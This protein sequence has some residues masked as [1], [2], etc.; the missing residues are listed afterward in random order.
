VSPDLGE[1]AALKVIPGDHTQLGAG[2]HSQL[3]AGDHSQLAAGHQ[4]TPGSG[5][6]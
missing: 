1:P 6:K 5:T 2:D 4:L 3:A